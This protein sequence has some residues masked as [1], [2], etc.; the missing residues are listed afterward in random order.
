M[1]GM[2]SR[3]VK[4]IISP[5]LMAW[6]LTVAAFAAERDVLICS[7]SNLSPDLRKAVADFTV[8]VAQAPLLQALKAAGE[9]GVVKAQDSAALLN[10]KQY[11]LAAH[12]HLIVIG[13]PSRDELLQKVW[14]FTVS[15]DEAQ[16]SLYSQGWGYLQGDIGWIECDRNPFL[17]SQKIQA[18]PVGTILVKLS[19][20]S[21]AGLLAALKAF[22]QG[23]LG[24]FVPVGKL[25]RPQTTILDRDPDP[26]PLTVKIPSTVTLG[27]GK[28]A[29]LAGWYDVPENE[30]RAIEEAAGDLPPRKIRRYK[31]L[32]PGFLEE[33]SIVRWLAG[34]HR[35]A[36]GNALNVIEFASAKD[37]AAAAEKMAARDKY[38]PLPGQP[39]AWSTPIGNWQNNKDEVIEE[40][41]W[42]VTLTV[43]G[44]RVILAT[45]PADVTLAIARQL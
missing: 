26:A 13:L 8:S 18:A 34:P 14:G 45:L 28:T 31:W 12:N 7:G 5:L 25:T 38:E 17:H 2:N 36:F 10:P 30:Y 37:A 41:Y 32:A 3:P 35:M 6:G 27:G 39:A 16:K 43:R 23:L 33:K 22:Q 29:T 20:T 11:D 19:G 9:Y 42:H 24:G 4:L 21:E 44:N 15:V 40:A 1:H